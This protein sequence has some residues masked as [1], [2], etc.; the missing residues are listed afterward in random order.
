MAAQNIC[1]ASGMAHRTN[2]QPRAE[3][4]SGYWGNSGHWP[5][6]FRKSSFWLAA[7]REGGSNS[8][9]LPAV[10]AAQRHVP[11]RP[12]LNVRYGVPAKRLHRA[13]ALHAD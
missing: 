10:P 2:S 12:D 7:A 11:L 1:V 5:E 8:C 4:V 13:Y 6:R 9:P 3:C